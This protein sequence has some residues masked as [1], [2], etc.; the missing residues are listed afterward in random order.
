MDRMKLV[1]YISALTAAVAAANSVVA[2]PYSVP[3]LVLMNSILHFF[4]ADVS[5]S[6]KDVGLSTN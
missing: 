4:N 2:I 3:L 1:K 6:K 5:A